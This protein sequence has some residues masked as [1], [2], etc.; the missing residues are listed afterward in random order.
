VG[1]DSEKVAGLGW[2]CRECEQA[3][4]HFGSKVEWNE[5]RRS[6][7][8][9]EKTA[10]LASCRRVNRVVTKREAEDL[11]PETTRLLSVKVGPYPGS[12][13]GP[14]SCG[15]KKESRGSRSTGDKRAW[16]WKPKKERLAANRSFL[17]RAKSVL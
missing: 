8:K 2:M 10:D 4:S 16:A 6:K 13:W 15:A 9:K 3:G 12:T 7:C 11:N 17:Q 5:R 1:R 14:Q